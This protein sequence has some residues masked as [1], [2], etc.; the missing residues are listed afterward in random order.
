MVGCLGHLIARLFFGFAETPTMF[1]VGGAI[2]TFGPIATPVLKSMVS[3]AVEGT[4]RG[5]IFAI[6]SIF[7]NG[8]PF[9]GG[10]LYSKVMA[11]FNGFG[12]YFF[13]FF[14]FGFFLGLCGY[15]WSN[16]R[17]FLVNR[18]YPSYCFYYITVS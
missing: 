1:Y 8:G 7:N 6:A 11:L 3:K 15:N 10:I 9:I 2:S 13:N 14:S 5:K 4:E 17:N 16:G 18:I 12:M